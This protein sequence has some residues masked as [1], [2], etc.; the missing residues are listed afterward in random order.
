VYLG[1]DLNAVTQ[2][3]HLGND[4]VVLL[5]EPW[6]YNGVSPED[7][8]GDNKVNLADFSIMASN[9]SCP[10]FKGNKTSGS[11]NPV[12]LAEATQ[13]YWRVDAIDASNNVYPGDVWT[14]STYNTTVLRQQILAKYDN[15]GVPYVLNNQKL[16]GYN[17]TGDP[18][19]ILA[20]QINSTDLDP[21]ENS[22]NQRNEGAI[23]PLAF[24]YVN[25]NS[26]YYRN[27]NVLY[28]ILLAL[29]YSCRAQG[30]N[31]GFNEK[32][33]F[34]NGQFGWCGVTLP[35]GGNNTRTDGASTVMGFPFFCIGRAIVMLQNEP[36]FVSALDNVYIDNDGN[37]SADVKRRDAY[38]YM[39]DN[40]IN[41]GTMTG[42]IQCMMTGKCKG[43][44]PNQDVGALAA[45]QACNEA[46]TFLN[47]GTPYLTQ[48][49]L[50]S[51][52]DLV[53]FNRGW[54]SSKY[55]I[56]EV[57]HGG[58]GYDSGYGNTIPS[59]LGSYARHANDS[60]VGNFITNYMNGYQYFFVLDD[61]WNDGGYWEYRTARRQGDCTMPLFA[62][63]M[64]QPYHSG[65]ALIYD[66]TLSKCA[67]N[68]SIFLNVPWSGG[69]E[70]S[71]MGEL[72]NHWSNPVD[73]DY[74]LPCNRPETFTY[75]DSGA[76]LEVVKT[77]ASSETVTWKA[78]DWDG[79]TMT[80][81]Y[82]AP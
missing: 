54:F 6:L 14:F 16:P 69:L 75:T 4:D 55:M 12:G 76:S 23:Y 25:T 51:H 60:V 81:T 1:T 15:E 2:A 53:L 36:A 3:E 17:P 5:T 47:N 37:G 68:P 82:E 48:A 29:D 35:N 52:R 49:Q 11:C 13:Y 80:Y 19:D 26:I 72:I 71:A 65:Y 42:I 74:V 18:K 20:G 56:L 43:G 58:E 62:A 21:L 70:S 40:N 22:F 41:G 27:A 73:S 45:I 24:C 79:G 78:F 67:K 32:Y 63:G 9:W 59:L 34:W 44:H 61:A 50:D 7:R 66:K 33:D 28:R 39:F 77:G 8:N 46:Y 31:G 64:S 57:G 10:E 30:K 38:K